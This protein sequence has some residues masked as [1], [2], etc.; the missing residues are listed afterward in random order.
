MNLKVKLNL[1]ENLLVKKLKILICVLKFKNVL[2]KSIFSDLGDKENVTNEYII[3]DEPE[4]EVV[5]PET[6]TGRGMHSMDLNRPLFRWLRDNVE[7]ARVRLAQSEHIRYEV[8]RLQDELCQR[9][10][11]EVFQMA[12]VHGFLRLMPSYLA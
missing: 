12:H 11:L 8:E 10:E 3:R 2:L 1:R 7:S 5:D 9:L 6:P 4:P